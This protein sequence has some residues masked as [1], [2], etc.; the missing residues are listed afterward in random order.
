MDYDKPVWRKLGARHIAAKV[1]YELRR[2]TAP[3][4]ARRTPLSG[5]TF[6]LWEREYSYFIHRHNSTWLNERAVEL[7]I[8]IDFVK[9]ATGNG[10]E[11]GNVLMHYGHRGG[12]DIVDRYERRPGVRNIDILNYDLNARLDFIVSISTLEHV[13]FDERP[14]DPGKVVAAFEH[15]TALLAPGGR[16]LLTAPL[17]HN[18]ALDQAVL[19]GRW[20]PARQATLVRTEGR[21]AATRELEW[22]PYRGKG[23]TGADSVWVCEVHR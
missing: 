8:A 19:S 7:P 20:A 17:G 12:W 6:E 3:F 1:S 14:R 13:G 23:G 22:R 18:A 16:M 15:L 10:L 2:L 5:A 21:W 9:G 11:F 4:S